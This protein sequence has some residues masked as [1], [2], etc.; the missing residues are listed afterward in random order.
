MTIF[1]AKEVNWHRHMTWLT[2]LIDYYNTDLKVEPLAN[3]VTGRRIQCGISNTNRRTH[4]YDEQQ[5]TGGS[6][7][8][9]INGQFE[10]HQPRI[11]RPGG[12]T[13]YKGI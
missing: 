3:K 7:C 6:I 2:W 9:R 12:R 13:K 1:D 4:G 5:L 8:A 10:A 11:G